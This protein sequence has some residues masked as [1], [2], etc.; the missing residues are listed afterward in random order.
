M[1]GCTT[2]SSPPSPIPYRTPAP[3]FSIPKPGGLFQSPDG[4][5]V[6][7]VDSACTSVTV[8]H[9]QPEEGEQPAADGR[10]GV[11]VRP[12]AVPVRSFRATFIS[13]QSLCKEDVVVACCW[14][15][16]G[17]RLAA[18]YASGHVYVLDRCASNA[19]SLARIACTQPVKPGM[20]CAD[21]RSGRS[22]WA[23]LNH[24]SAVAVAAH[25]GACV[26]HTHGVALSHG[27]QPLFVL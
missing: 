15:T 6:A 10:G 7:V 1:H 19:S 5:A 8:L 17:S 11:P 16:D 22:A 4:S 2:S 23:R 27:S 21:G 26:G 18:A 25:A 20:V 9:C 13:P 24:W 12:C 14:A 3:S